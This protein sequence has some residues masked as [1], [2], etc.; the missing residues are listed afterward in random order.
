[1]RD[2]E[3]AEIQREEIAK[4]DN[5]KYLC[6]TVQSNG[7]DGQE[8]GKQIQAGWNSSKN[9]SGARCDRRVSAKM[10]DNVYKTVL[11][12]AIMY[13]LEIVAL[14]KWQEAQPKVVKIK[15]LSLHDG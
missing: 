4:V 1:M 11:R 14:K 15:V 9:V 3:E 2:L 8:V 7:D 10:K 5:F 12:L 13:G 6:S